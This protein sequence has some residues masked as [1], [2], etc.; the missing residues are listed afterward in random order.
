MR[1]EPSIAIFIIAYQAASTLISAYKRIP[2]NLKRKA[3]EIYCFDDCSDDNTYYAGLGYK[4][5]NNI[6]NFILYKN[7][8][9]LGYGGNQKKG[10]NYALKKN[11][12]IV[13]MLH[14]DAQYAPEKMPLLIDPFLKDDSEK[15]GIVMGSRM[16]GN[17]LKGGMPIYKFLG[18]KILTFLENLILRTNLSEFHSGYRAFNINALKEMPFNKCS[19]D[20]HFDTEIIIMM[21]HAGY[22]IVEVPIPTYYGPGSK[23]YVNVFKYGLDCL[24][25]V[26]NYRLMQL[27]IKKNSKFDF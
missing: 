22:K 24:I 25:A 4:H 9:N 10:Y 3:R 13:V 12:D 1:K 23:S 15:I 6:K 26:I 7:P 2:E 5:A 19:N 27:G 17:P 21:L 11:Y 18:N 20:F 8:K 16:L 14:G